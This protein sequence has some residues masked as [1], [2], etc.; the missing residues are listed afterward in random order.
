MRFKY[1]LSMISE[2]WLVVITNLDRWE[3]FSDAMIAFLCAI[4][5]LA[6]SRAAFI[7]VE[8]D[9]ITIIFSIASA[10]SCVLIDNLPIFSV[11]L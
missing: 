7:L 8:I 4:V 11:R 5:I 9:S 3:C 10:F 1:I 2:S 6:D